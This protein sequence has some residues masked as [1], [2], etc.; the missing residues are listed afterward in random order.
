MAS[1]FLPLPVR[2][3]ADQVGDGRSSKARHISVHAECRR[4]G[5]YSHCKRVHIRTDQGWLP[6]A[7]PS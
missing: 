1:L 3:H 2:V 7:G 5:Y 4:L 6:S